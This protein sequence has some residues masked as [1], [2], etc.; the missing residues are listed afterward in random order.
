[1][2]HPFVAR[3]RILSIS[4]RG[5]I[6][7]DVGGRLVLGQL[8]EGGGWIGD[9]MEGDMR[10]GLRIW[11][12]P[13][14]GITASLQVLMAEVADVGADVQDHVTAPVPGWEDTRAA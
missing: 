13:R 1:M 7:L 12:N 10:P 3:G 5:R 6:A 8:F 11:R 4:S 14:N 2:S 9:Q